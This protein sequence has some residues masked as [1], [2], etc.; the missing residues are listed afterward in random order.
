MGL[1]LL[2][3]FANTFLVMGLGPVRI[4][5]AFYLPLLLIF[6]IA[7]FLQHNEESYVRQIKS[8][9]EIRGNESLPIAQEVSASSESGY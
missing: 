8:R 7:Y 6:G 4:F 1:A 5:V 9:F 3:I 2:T